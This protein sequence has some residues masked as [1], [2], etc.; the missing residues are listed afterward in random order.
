MVLNNSAA[1]GGE[2][3]MEP[4]ILPPA[5]TA[6]QSSSYGKGG[7][8]KLKKWKV[9]PLKSDII[10]RDTQELAS[11]ETKRLREG[12]IVEQTGPEL[13]LEV[14]DPNTGV[15]RGYV[16]RMP[17]THPQA[18]NY[19]QPIGWVTLSAKQL[20]GPEYF[21]PGPQAVEVQVGGKKGS[22]KGKKASAYMMQGM[23][24][25]WGGAA[26]TLYKGGAVGGAA[27]YM[28]GGAVGGKAAA[29]GFYASKSSKGKGVNKGGPKGNL[30]WTA[31]S[32]PSQPATA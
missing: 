2:N 30:T 6:S 11:T 7:K 18:I 9:A 12:E 28:Y 14:K 31:P 23:S 10:V 25:A 20:G 15:R 19:P 32:P 1:G 17:I 13:H 8:W 5:G 4:V 21:L 3:Y 22:A 29:A 26:A 27:A 16:T 24:T